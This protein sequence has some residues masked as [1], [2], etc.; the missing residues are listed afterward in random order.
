MW[1][2]WFL[3]QSSEVSSP[4]TLLH[5]ARRFE[6]VVALPMSYMQT[7]DRLADVLLPPGV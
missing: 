5:F 7:P 6:I 3:A 1:L 2:S 4:T